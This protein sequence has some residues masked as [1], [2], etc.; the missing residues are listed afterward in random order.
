MNCG[1]C[2]QGSGS[3]VRM[4]ATDRRRRRWDTARSGSDGMLLV[5]RAAA[6]ATGLLVPPVGVGHMILT[7]LLSGH[8]FSNILQQALRQPSRSTIVPPRAN[9]PAAWFTVHG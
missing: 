6:S 4:R 7:A 5:T 9:A 8:K 2:R 3:C 1:H